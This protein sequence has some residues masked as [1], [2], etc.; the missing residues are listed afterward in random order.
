MD[1]GRAGVERLADDLADVGI[2]SEVE[3]GSRLEVAARGRARDRDRGTPVR[4]EREGESELIDSLP[5]AS[6]ARALT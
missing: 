5:A 3:R 4:R 6:R 1:H 2:V